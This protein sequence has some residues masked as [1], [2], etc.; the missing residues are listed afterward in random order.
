METFY[1]AE[2]TPFEIFYQTK[3]ET[4]ENF[5]KAKIAHL[6]N[7]LESK[8]NTFEGGHT[9]T[10]THAQFALYIRMNAFHALYILN[11]NEM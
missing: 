6:R 7:F 5:Y 2:I 1:K 9:D 10:H 4:C 11:Q 3:I 8:N